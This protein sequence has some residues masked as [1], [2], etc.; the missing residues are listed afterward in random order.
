MATKAD[1][2]VG[3]VGTLYK[4]EIQDDG[5][6][7]PDLLSVSDAVIIWKTPSGLITRNIAQ[8]VEVTTASG[9]YYVQYIILPADVTAGIHA[10]KG[11]YKWQGYVEF[12]GN[13]KYHTN[14]EE[15]TVEKNLN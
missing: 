3:D 2:H 12:P 5:A 9:K 15:Y 7:F 4:A 8:G 14:I 13:Q 1:V 6:A 10:K 11:T